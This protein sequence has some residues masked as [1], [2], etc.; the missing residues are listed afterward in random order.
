MTGVDKVGELNIKKTKKK[1]LGASNSTYKSIYYLE[2]KQAKEF[3]WGKGLSVVEESSVLFWRPW[4]AQRD[5]AIFQ[6]SFAN[7]LLRNGGTLM[8]M[9]REMRWGN[10]LYN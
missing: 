5:N 3:T 6:L 2:L 4:G 10:E 9:T 8:I 7:S 1:C